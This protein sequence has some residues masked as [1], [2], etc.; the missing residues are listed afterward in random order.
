M[1]FRIFKRK[2]K[3]MP[4]ERVHRYILFWGYSDNGD[5]DFV[6]FLGPFQ[7]LKIAVNSGYIFKHV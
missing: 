6:N 1:V 7:C 5:S 4:P 2:Y 3:F